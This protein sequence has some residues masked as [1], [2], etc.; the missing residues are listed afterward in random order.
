VISLD[1]REQQICR[2]GGLDDFPKFQPEAEGELVIVAGRFGR[3]EAHLRGVIDEIM[4]VWTKCPKPAELRALLDRDR[5]E[6][7]DVNCPLCQ[8]SGWKIIEVEGNSGAARCHCGSIPRP[9]G[10]SLPYADK[11]HFGHSSDLKRVEPG[12]LI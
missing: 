3:S 11:R 5:E 4:A 12:D 10:G 1:F 7:V 8:G 6:K 9:P 2:M